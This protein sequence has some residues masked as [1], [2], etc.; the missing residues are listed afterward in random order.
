[1]VPLIR[2]GPKEARKRG[3]SAITAAYGPAEME[4]LCSTLA[5]FVEP[6]RGPDGAWKVMAVAL[7]PTKPGSRFWEVWRLKRRTGEAAAGEAVKG[8]SGPA[9]KGGKF[10]VSA[11]AAKRA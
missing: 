11:A 9:V 2:E 6:K 5:G 7:V 8:R 10:I 4:L 1:M 3:Y